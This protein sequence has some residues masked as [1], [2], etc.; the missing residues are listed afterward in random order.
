MQFVHFGCLFFQM[1]E[2]GFFRLFFADSVK[3]RRYFPFNLRKINKKQSVKAEKNV[4]SSKKRRPCHVSQD[5]MSGKTSQ[6]LKR[7]MYFLSSVRN[8]V[9]GLLTMGIFANNV[10]DYLCILH[11]VLFSFCAILC[12]HQF[13]TSI[14]GAA[15]LFLLRFIRF[16][17]QGVHHEQ[18]L[19]KNQTLLSDRPPL[20]PAADCSAGE[21]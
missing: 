13:D 2:T 6:C 19:P 5:T 8:K 16:H 3:K 18:G 7:S 4:P 21:D 14:S 9:S 17:S 11:A 1:T 20:S 12:L 15:V 10:S